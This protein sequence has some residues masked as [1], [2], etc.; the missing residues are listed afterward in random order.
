MCKH[1]EKTSA[2]LKVDHKPGACMSMSSLMGSLGSKG[3]KPAD[4]DVI[5]IK[6]YEPSAGQER[7]RTYLQKKIFDEE[8]DFG[9]GFKSWE[10]SRYVKKVMKIY[11]DCGKLKLNE[12]R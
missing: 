6:P 5:I 1:L 3:S 11:K 7:T 9:N 8:P 4:E 12:V 10:K 2:I